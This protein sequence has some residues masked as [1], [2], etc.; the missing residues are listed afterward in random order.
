MRKIQSIPTKHLNYKSPTTTKATAR[1]RLTIM[2]L[3]I[4]KEFLKAN[5]EVDILLSNLICSKWDAIFIVFN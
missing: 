5:H 4:R 2:S 3:Y 1:G